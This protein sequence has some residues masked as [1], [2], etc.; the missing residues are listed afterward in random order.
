M[1]DTDDKFL[2]FSHW[3]N[4]GNNDINISV[5]KTWSVRGVTDS[6][7]ISTLFS[8]IEYN[9]VNEDTTTFLNTFYSESKKWPNAYFATGNHNVSGIIID[10]YNL[11]AC[12]SVSVYVTQNISQ[13]TEAVDNFIIWV[14]DTYTDILDDI[15]TTTTTSDN[16][17]NTNTTTAETRQVKLI[18]M[19]YQVQCK[20]YTQYIH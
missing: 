1:L 19:H 15:F 8:S 10:E 12:E 7:N 16:F 5:T 6:N 17:N 14:I 11:A 20:Y 3:W 4:D 2:L 18:Q 9:F 13:L